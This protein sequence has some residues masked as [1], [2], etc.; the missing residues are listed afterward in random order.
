VDPR[1]RT[2]RKSKRCHQLAKSSV[3]RYLRC[4]KAHAQR[5]TA[6][7][8][9]Q[10]DEG[11]PGSLAQFVDHLQSRG[12]YVFRRDEAI[13]ALA[14][15]DIALKFAA[16]R[17]VA[18]SRLAMPRRGFF[19]IVPLEYAAAG[20]PPATW[21]VDDLMAFEEAPYYVGLLSAAALYGAAHQ[22]PQELQV[23]TS[24]SLRPTVAGRTRL[25]F[26]LKREAERTPVNEQ[27]TETGTMRVSTPEATAL[28]LVRY[29]ATMGGTGAV[30][31]VL[32]ELAERLDPKRLVAAA[33]AD[34]ELSV[35]QRTGFIL[36]HVGANAKTEPLARWVAEQRP[37]AALLRAGK[38]ERKG[39]PDPRWSII[40][41]ESIEVDE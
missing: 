30:A 1:G 19:V 25:R 11:E 40:E 37:R 3:A 35:A 2:R 7:T 39:A 27:K 16:R 24:S 6:R 21:F 23:V 29:E 14:V 32:S 26:I 38:G 18:K 4:V 22:Q 33:R 31:T 28:D 34:V 20:A 36:D 41:N 9:P 17:L 12:R 8:F 10:V 13:R 5:S 15:S